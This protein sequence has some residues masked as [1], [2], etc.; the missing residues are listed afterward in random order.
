MIAL[1][2]IIAASAAF[3]L[4][5][6]LCAAGVIPA[7]AGIGIRIPA[8]RQSETAW[9]VGHKAAYVPTLV[10]GTVAIVVSGIGIAIPSTSSVAGLVGAVVLALTLAWATLAAHRAASSISSE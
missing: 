9:K 10:G 6:A 7:N 3:V 8:T 2:T 1:V 4:I 5:V